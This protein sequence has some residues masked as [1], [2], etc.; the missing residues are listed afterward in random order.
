MNPGPSNAIP[1][2]KSEV[3]FEGVR[4]WGVCSAPQRS[5]ATQLHICVKRSQRAFPTLIPCRP[6][7]LRHK[8]S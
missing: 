8:M 4:G 6:L 1:F 5:G 3:L 7:Y 2:T